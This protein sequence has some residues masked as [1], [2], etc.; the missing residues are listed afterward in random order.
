M[1]CNQAMGKKGKKILIK[2]IIKKN[3]NK[4]NILPAMA[5]YQAME[6]KRKKIF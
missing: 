3:F 6:K 1:A 2:N 4:K 5:D